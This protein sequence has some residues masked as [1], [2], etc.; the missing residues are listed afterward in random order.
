[1]EFLIVTTDLTNLAVHQWNRISA[2]KRNIS[3]AKH[4]EFVFRLLGIAMDPLT[5]TII[6][7]KKIVDRFRVP[8]IST[9]AK[10]LNASSKLTFAMEKMIVVTTLMNLTNTLA[11]HLHLDAQSANGNVLESRLV[12]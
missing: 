2:I 6:P 3:D 5:A 9:N 11:S 10:T 12:A 8:T 1:M 7:T 4:Q